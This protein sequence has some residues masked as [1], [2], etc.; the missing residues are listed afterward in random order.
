MLDLA[1][2]DRRKAAF[3]APH[4]PEPAPLES[5]DVVHPMPAHAC[6]TYPHALGAAMPSL[7]FAVLLGWTLRRPDAAPVT[8][9]RLRVGTH[10]YGKPLVVRAGELTP[11]LITRTGARYALP[12]PHFQQVVLEGAP[13]DASV[14]AV[15]MRAWDGS[16][17]VCA[18]LVIPGVL[19]RL[20]GLVV[21]PHDPMWPAP[22]SSTLPR[23]LRVHFPRVSER[24]EVPPLPDVDPNG[25]PLGARW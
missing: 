21:P 22:T 17:L 15:G 6:D 2:L 16:E 19:A 1:E 9:A 7:Q 11:A 13:P 3:E 18:E 20:Q 23:S 8:G 5:D 4:D 25:E 12:L 10:M 24:F 14:V